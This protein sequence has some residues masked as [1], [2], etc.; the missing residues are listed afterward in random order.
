LSSTLPGA[1]I[2]IRLCSIPSKKLAP[3]WAK[4]AT[5]LKGEINIAKVDATTE[6]ELAQRFK[7]EGFPSLKYFA[8]KVHD[9]TKAEEFGGDREY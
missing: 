4:L 2:G 6:T 8:S 5:K 9:D 3:E 1:S 7:V